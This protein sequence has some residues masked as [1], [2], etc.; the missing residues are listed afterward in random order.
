MESRLIICIVIVLLI[1]YGLNRV[2]DYIEGNHL[3]KYDD[4]N[5]YRRKCKK[6]GAQQDL[7]HYSWNPRATW[8]EE[9]YP[10]GNDPNCE[11]HK[12]ADNHG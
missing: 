9:M 11:C 1:G 8:W 10:I 6:C 7:H 4:T 5:P 12:Y 2:N 3:F